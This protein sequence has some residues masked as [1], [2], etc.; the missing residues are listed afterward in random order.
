M[1]GANRRPLNAEEYRRAAAR[2]M[3]EA[4]LL[5][6]VLGTPRR[7]GIALALGW[8]GYHTHRSQHSPAGFPDLCLVKGGRLVFA[9]LKTERGKT[10]AEQDGWLED[11]GVVE[12]RATTYADAVARHS[13]RPDNLVAVYLWRP[14]DLLEGRILTA[15]G[16]DTPPPGLALPY[17]TR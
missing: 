6:A 9:E 7:P 3:T 11:L 14:S 4:Q 16:G 15:L 12:A 17:A 13:T 10:T 2:A 5:D 1:S 8:R